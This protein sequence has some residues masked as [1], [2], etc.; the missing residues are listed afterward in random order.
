MALCPLVGIETTQL[1]ML[2]QMLSDD[3]EFTVKSLRH[4][5]DLNWD[6][7]DLNPVIWSSW[8]PLKVRGFAW[9]VRLNR[10]PSKKALQDRGVNMFSQECSMCFGSIETADHALNRCSFATVVWNCVR[11]WCGWDGM[12]MRI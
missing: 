10:I 4:A 5:I 1:Q 2:F 7:V 3:G 8:I 11:Q 6:P 12:L 9:K